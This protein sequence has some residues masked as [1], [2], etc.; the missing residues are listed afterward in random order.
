MPVVFFNSHLIEF[1]LDLVTNSSRDLA[2]KIGENAFNKVLPDP[3]R[4]KIK[5]VLTVAGQNVVPNAKPS[6]NNCRFCKFKNGCTEV[7]KETK[8]DFADSSD[9]LLSK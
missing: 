9:L 5:T 4:Q 3:I 2:N 8:D 7:F 1:K 6:S